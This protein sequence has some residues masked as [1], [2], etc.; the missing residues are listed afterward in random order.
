MI[1]AFASVLCLLNLLLLW[2]HRRSMRPVVSHFS[3]ESVGGEKREHYGGY[4]LNVGST[5]LRA[6][7]PPSEVPIKNSFPSSAA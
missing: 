1:L 3:L 5:V 4:G 6:V 2:A 7:Q